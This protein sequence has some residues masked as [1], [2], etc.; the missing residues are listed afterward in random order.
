MPL[1]QAERD[2]IL[3]VASEGTKQD[4]ADEIAKKTVLSNNELMKLLSEADQKALAL[5]VVEVTNA[6]KTNRQKTDAVKGIAGGVE[7]LV[8]VAGLLL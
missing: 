7:I 3:K 2:E 4:L 6:T 1:T 8:K 5:M